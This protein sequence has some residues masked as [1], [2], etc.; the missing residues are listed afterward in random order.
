MVSFRYTVYCLDWYN[1]PEVVYAQE[2][3]ATV[4][5]SIEGVQ[6]EIHTQFGSATA[7]DQSTDKEDT[8]IRTTPYVN[9][10][11][12]SLLLKQN[13]TVRLKENQRETVKF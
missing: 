11:K 6:E 3:R 9:Q 10:Q 13:S 1:R 12:F 8:I 7:I 4:W 2:N 5:M